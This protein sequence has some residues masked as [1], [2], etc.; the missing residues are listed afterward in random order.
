MPCLAALGREEMLHLLVLFVFTTTLMM[1]NRAVSQV[2]GYLLPPAAHILEQPECPATIKK[3]K[4]TRKTKKGLLIPSQDG[5]VSGNGENHKVTLVNQG[6]R[7][8]VATRLVFLSFDIWDQYLS[9]WHHDYIRIIPMK[10]K[11][12]T[13]Y[14]RWF[15]S[16]FP[17]H[18]GI[19]YIDRVRFRAGM[20]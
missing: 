16:V 19:V 2:L 3:Y 9:T 15:V 8:I 10:E 11:R 13:K 12:D 14:G 7:V 20:I 4:V 18:T 17:L 5:D 1:P 6:E